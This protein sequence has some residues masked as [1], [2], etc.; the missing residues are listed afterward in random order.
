MRLRKENLCIYF[1]YQNLFLFSFLFCAHWIEKK[2]RKNQHC[3][4][5]KLIFLLWLFH[6]FLLIFLFSFSF[7]VCFPLFIVVVGVTFSS[8]LF[9]QFGK[10]KFAI[11]PNNSDSM[12]LTSNFW[13]FISFCMFVGWLT[14]NP[15]NKYEIK[16]SQIKRGAKHHYILWRYR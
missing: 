10:I 6:V 4:C 11:K 15:L 3:K 1:A 2:E 13:L 5:H 9:H 14:K 12:R 8:C 16:Q 7:S